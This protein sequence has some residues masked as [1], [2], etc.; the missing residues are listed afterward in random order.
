MFHV[1]VRGYHLIQDG[2]E[3]TQGQWETGV[4]NTEDGGAELRELLRE[5]TLGIV[6]PEW[7]QWEASSACLQDSWGF[8]QSGMAV[9]RQ[10]SERHTSTCG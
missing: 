3:F 8:V 9:C 10:P 4:A 6:N 7:T 5:R 1:L 2:K